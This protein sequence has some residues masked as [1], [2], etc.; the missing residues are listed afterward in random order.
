MICLSSEGDL[1]LGLRSVLEARAQPVQHIAKW[2][3]QNKRALFVF[4]RSKEEK[5]PKKIK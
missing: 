3:K 2:L 4:L 1:W 5:W